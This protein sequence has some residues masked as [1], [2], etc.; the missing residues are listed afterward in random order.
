MNKVQRKIM[1]YVL[2]VL[3]VFAIILFFASPKITGFFIAEPNMAYKNLDTVVTI[4]TYTNQLIPENA[5]I[6]VS[7]ANQTAGMPV[8]EFIYRSGGPFNYINSENPA[9]KYKGYG[10]RG[11]YNYSLNLRY[12]NINTTLPLGNHTLNLEVLYDYFI[13]SEY[14]VN[15]TVD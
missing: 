9:I 3:T 1:P 10:F 12:F 6:V 11:D 2:P 13:L 8:M 14:S 4:N 7:M 5:T 15:L